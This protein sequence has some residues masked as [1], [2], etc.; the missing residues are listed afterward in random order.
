VYREK[1]LDD[2]SENPILEVE[3]SSIKETSPN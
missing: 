2:M 3:I 1:S